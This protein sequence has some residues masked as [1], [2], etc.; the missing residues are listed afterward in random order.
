MTVIEKAVNLLDHGPLSRKAYRSLR[1]PE[2]VVATERVPVRGGKA[3]HSQALGK[4]AGT[5]SRLGG[6]PLA[7]VFCN[8][9]VKEAGEDAGLEGLCGGVGVVCGAEVEGRAFS[10]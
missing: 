8:N 9:V 3:L 5:P 4:I 2:G 10:S 7:A 1:M 6:V